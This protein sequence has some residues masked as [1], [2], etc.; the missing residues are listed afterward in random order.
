MRK[1]YHHLFVCCVILMSL[2]AIK[3]NGQDKPALPR[4]IPDKLL[5][6]RLGTVVKIEKYTLQPPK[7]YHFLHKNGPEGA[8]MFA[9]VS[10]ER[11][12]GTKATLLL[13]LV[14]P[15]VGE[16][17]KYA[18]D[19]LADKLLGGVKR[20]RTN[21]HQEKTEIGLVNGLTFARINWTGT[22]PIHDLKMKGFNYVAIDG[23][24]IIQLSSQDILSEA[25]QALPIAEAA[26]LTLKK[27][28]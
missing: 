11:K 19:Q 7:D 10:D 3:T 21:W 25:N 26:I 9:W 23:D 16:A 28:P 5:A 13:N 15:P 18:L 20:R 22:E 27:Q 17:T 1:T 8:K 12:D 24:T 2:A 14:A 6:K 4:W